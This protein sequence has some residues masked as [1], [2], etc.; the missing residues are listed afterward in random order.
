MKEKNYA[1]LKS[2]GIAFIDDKKV[3]IKGSEVGYSLQTIGKI[4]SLKPEE[5]QRILKQKDEQPS[6]YRKEE[7]AIQKTQ[8]TTQ[9]S[10]HEMH[11]SEAGKILELLLKPEQQ[12]KRINPALL[13]KKK[14]KRK[15][16]HL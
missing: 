9:R 7:M 11:Q 14:R 8:L 1:V 2:R 12:I 6:G 10:A 13:Q 16:L 15:R 4:L 5:K 3:K